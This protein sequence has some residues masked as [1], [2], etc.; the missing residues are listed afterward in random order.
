M[1]VSKKQIHAVAAYTDTSGTRPVIAGVLVDTEKQRLVG[2]DGYALLVLPI[3]P[4]SLS[5]KADDIGGMHELDKPVILDAKQLLQ[6]AKA[7]PKTSRT[8]PAHEGIVLCHNGGESIRAVNPL[9]GMEQRLVKIEGN[10]PKYDS[11]IPPFDPEAK[12]IN[13]DPKYLAR[14]ASTANHVGA[15]CI[16]LQVG[17]TPGQPIRADFISYECQCVMAVVMPMEIKADSLKHLVSKEETANV[18]E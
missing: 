10:Y 3:K 17:A 13:I 18:A 1:Y 7:I 9:H 6:T 11:I 4:D 2:A 5:P 12:C 16:R 8:M 14:L 15:Y